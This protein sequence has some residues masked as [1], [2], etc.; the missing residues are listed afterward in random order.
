MFRKFHIQIMQLDLQRLAE[1]SSDL[2]DNV[3]GAGSLRPWPESADP[4]CVI[5]SLLS[6]MAL[7]D[8]FQAVS[9]LDLRAFMMINTLAIVANV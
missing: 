4:N 1:R 6:C 3:L 2:L 8:T 5:I 9:N 7:N